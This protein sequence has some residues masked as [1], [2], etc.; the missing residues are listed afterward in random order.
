MVGFRHADD[1]L[2]RPVLME[3]LERM[4][5]F[6]DC[7]QSFLPPHVRRNDF[8]MKDGAFDAPFWPKFR[9]Q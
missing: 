8:P 7:E 5:P 1:I 6:V 4:R 9:D 2:E 3:W